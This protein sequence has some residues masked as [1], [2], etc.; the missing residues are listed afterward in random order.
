MDIVD[1]I[2]ERLGWDSKPKGWNL[3][4]MRKFAK[5]LT[6]KDPTESGWFSACTTKLSKHFD[7]PE[8]ICASLRDSLTG[9]TLWRGKGKNI[10]KAVEQEK[11]KKK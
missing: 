6:D 11:E 4:S 1:K 7:E 2:N 9:T 8:K 5:T 3:R 10:K